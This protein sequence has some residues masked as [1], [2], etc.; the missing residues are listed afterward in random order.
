VSLNFKNLDVDD[1]YMTGDPV[2]CLKCKAVMS[3][4][5][6]ASEVEPWICEFCGHDNKANV[7]EAEKKALA[8]EMTFL[9]EKPAIQEKKTVSIVTLLPATLPP[10]TFSFLFAFTETLFQKTVSDDDSMI[11]FCI[12]IR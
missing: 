10:H 12:D 4:L 11:I 9:L 6:K 5:S 2:S 3:S 7:M 1:Q 8:K